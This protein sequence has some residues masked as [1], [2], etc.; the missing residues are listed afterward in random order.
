[1]SIF[2]TVSLPCPAC[3]TPISFDLVISVSA[4]RRPDLRDAILDGSFQRLACPSCATSV[5]AD[6]EFTYM[7]IANGQYIGVWP[8][9][10]RREWKD[11]SAK[12]RAVFDDALGKNATPEAKR[13]GEKVE[14]RAVFGWNALVEKILAR[15]AGIDDRSLEL[16]KITVMR[17]A[18]E[19]PVPGDL[20]LRLVAVDDTS[21][22]LA[23][24]GGEEEEQPDQAVRVPRQL[25]ADIEGDAAAWQDARD[26][27]SEGDVVDFQREMLLPA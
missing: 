10:K 16:A 26:A 13:I 9:D 12:T 5:R 19:T 18:K 8:I 22:L 15:L 24:L 2:R 11:W 4:D 25:L 1:M 23:W 21:L 17:T 3:A 20:E 27:V 14:V 6:P 7:D